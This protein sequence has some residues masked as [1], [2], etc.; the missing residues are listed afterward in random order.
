MQV[1]CVQE[2]R[3]E[4]KIL[5]GNTEGKNHSENLGE[6]G[7]YYKITKLYSLRYTDIPTRNG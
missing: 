5:V 7:G 4:Y 1:V 6:K 2:I 3:N